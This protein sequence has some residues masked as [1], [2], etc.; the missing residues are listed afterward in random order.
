MKTIK[1]YIRKSIYGA[2]LGSMT[3]ATVSCDNILDTKPQGVFSAEQIGNDEAIDLMTAAY[4]TLLCHYFGN[5]ES[6]AGPINNWVIDLRSDDALKGGDG[7]TM[8]AYMH[9]LEI[10][11]VMNDSPILDFKWRNNCYSVARCNTAIRAIAAASNLS[12][13]DQQSF[14][15]EMKTLRAYYN[16][17]MYRLFEKFPYIDEDANPSEVRADQYTRAEIVDMIRKDLRDAYDILPAKQSQAG[18]FNKYVAASILA[19][20]A[21]YESDWAEVEKYA[22]FVISSGQYD[23]YPN[24]LDMSKPEM[25]NTYESIMAVQFSSANSPNQYNFC[26]C[27]NCTYNFLDADHT[28]TAYGNGDDFYLASQDLVNAF[29]TDASGLPYLD[30]TQNSEN[31][32]KADYAGN[33]DPRLDFTLGRIGMPWRG[34][35]YTE[36]WCRNLALY[37]QYSGK[38]P[39][40]SPDSPYVETGIVPWGASS[41]NCILIRYADVMLMKAEALIEQNKQLD[42]ARNLI[43][44]VRSKAARSVD[45]SYSPIDIDPTKA[46]YAVGQYPASGWSQDYARR[47]VRHER[48]VELAMEGHRWFDLVRWNTA[49]ETVNKYYQFESQFQPYYSGAHLS[50]SDI[51]FPVPL[52]QIENGGDLYK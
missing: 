23:L 14:I 48:R 29:R 5:N 30:G 10:G 46:H 13:E 24:F 40:P 28:T 12:S 47:A 27:L 51:Y 44:Q 17:D 45:P 36:H 25:N 3:L 8:E 41:L 34:Y 4:A 52:S 21:I 50:A 26:N 16:F 43:N 39:Y 15:A 1:S 6:F 49:V 11:N 37:G 35:E 18:R 22:G 19:K 33:V 9:Q 31:I 38:K 2:I 20:V 42:E 7:I 32:D